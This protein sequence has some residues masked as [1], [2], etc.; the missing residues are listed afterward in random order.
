MAQ[1]FKEEIL[2]NISFYVDKY[3]ILENDELKTATIL[4]PRYKNLEFMDSTTEK[5]KWYKAAVSTINSYLSE[6]GEP[7][8]ENNLNDSSD[9]FSDAGDEDLTFETTKKELDSYLLRHKMKS[10]TEFYTKYDKIY[11]RLSKAAEYFLLIPGTSV[12]SERLF[13]HI[14]FQVK[15]QML[16]LK[17]FGMQ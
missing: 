17:S 11:P 16:Y 4:H 10:V 5:K 2:T 6:N 3:G 13:S 7:Q 15:P 12:A 8:F 9:G 1:V 14:G